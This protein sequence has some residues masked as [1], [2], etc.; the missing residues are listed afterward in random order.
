MFR[1]FFFSSRRAPT[2]SLCDLGSDVCSSDLLFVVGGLVLLPVSL[3][4]GSLRSVKVG[5][6]KSAGRGRSENLVVGG[7]IKKN[8]ECRMQ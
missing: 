7:T 8:S 4:V 5:D 1:I 2:G 6:G 3:C